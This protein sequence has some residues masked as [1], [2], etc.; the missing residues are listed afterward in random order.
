MSISQHSH[1]GQASV[2]TNTLQE[3]FGLEGMEEF[4]IDF[5]EKHVIHAKDQ[6]DAESFKIAC[7]NIYHQKGTCDWG[8]FTI[9]VHP[10][11][12][13]LGAIKKALQPAKDKLASLCFT[14]D[15][16]EC[17]VGTL[18]QEVA[19]LTAPSSTAQPNPCEPKAVPEAPK[20]PLYDWWVGYDSESE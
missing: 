20:S 5:K 13:E 7:P 3:R 14:V 17:K 8:P 12:L 1:A 4:Y 15:V 9:S 18:K 19:S 16:L 10:Y 6:F 11:L 2:P